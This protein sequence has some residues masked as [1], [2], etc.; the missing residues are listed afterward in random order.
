MIRVVTSLVSVGVGMATIQ[1]KD[2]ATGIVS[3]EATMTV[4]P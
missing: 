4:V 3:N 1:A 2:P